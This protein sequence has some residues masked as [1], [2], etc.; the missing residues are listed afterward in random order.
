MPPSPLKRTVTVAQGAPL[1]GAYAD[2]DRIADGVL[3]RAVATAGFAGD[4]GTI[5]NLPGLGPYRQVRDHI[6]A[7][8]GE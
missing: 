1:E 4:R 2:V 3:Q 5:L 7:A 8:S 6:E